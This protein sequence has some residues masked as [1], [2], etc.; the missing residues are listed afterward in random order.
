V[1]A[2]AGAGVPVDVA[3][4]ARSYNIDVRHRAL[5]DSVSGML[6]IKDGQAAIV[7]LNSSHHSNRQRF[8]LA[9]ELGH[10]LMHGD[11]TKV[12]VDGSQLF[13]RDEAS[14]EGTRTQEIEAN[15][16]ASALLMPESALR[17]LV[18]DRPVDIHD[19][20]LMRRLAERFEVSVHALTI[21]LTRLGLAVG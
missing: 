15:A 6:L 1:L 3:A 2:R 4:I 11:N 18:G 20:A 16:F 12:F 13:F 5:E 21:R 9:H 19:E 7:G 8:T 17:R 10:L 14:S